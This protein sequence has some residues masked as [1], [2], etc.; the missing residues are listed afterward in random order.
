MTDFKNG[1]FDARADLDSG[2]LPENFTLDFLVNELRFVTGASD[3]YVAGYIS[4]VYG[5]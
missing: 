2:W 4:V 3:S 5:G 1:V